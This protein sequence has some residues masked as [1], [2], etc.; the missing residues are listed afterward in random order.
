MNWFKLLRN[1]AELDDVDDALKP[2]SASNVLDLAEW[3]RK[4]SASDQV[5]VVDSGAEACKTAL[6]LTRQWGKLHRHGASG[7]I[8]VCDRHPGTVKVPLNDLAALH[9]AVDERTVA[10]ILQPF[11]DV[12]DVTPAIHAYLLGVAQLCRELKI[13]LILDE[14][15]AEKGKARYEALLCEERFGVRA[16]IVILDNGIP[17][18][19]PRAA[20]LARGNVCA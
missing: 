16:D 13:L 3:L 11:E 7:I 1:S 20:V 8:S 17:G 2:T 9:A 14:T 10:I 4:N 15:Q 12:A 19:V 5:H 6:Q 18:G